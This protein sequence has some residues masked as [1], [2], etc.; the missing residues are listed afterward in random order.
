M[1]HLKMKI[2]SLFTHS[3]VVTNVY[4]FLLWLL[5]FFKISS[6]VFCKMKKVI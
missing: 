6:F 4:D 5:A 3:Q 1:V 2:V